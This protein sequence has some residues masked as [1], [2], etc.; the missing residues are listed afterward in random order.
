MSGTFQLGGELFP[1]DPLDKGWAPERVATRGTREPVF[2]D[3]WRFS[4][5]FGILKTQNE[6][7]FF[8]TKFRT[9]GLYTAVLPHPDTATLT[10]FTGVS[11]EDYSFSFNDY[12][13]NAYAVGA[14][15]SLSVDLRATGSA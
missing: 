1:K 4:C 6:S 10:T 3:I 14:R 15:L 11:I 12:E 8:M 2:A 13:R 5:S 9:G 7:D